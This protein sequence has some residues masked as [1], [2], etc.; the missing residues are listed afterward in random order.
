MSTPLRHNDHNNF[1]HGFYQQRSRDPYHSQWRSL[2]ASFKA[3]NVVA[4]LPNLSEFNNI[5]EVGSGTGELSHYLVEYFS[6]SPIHQ[7][8]VSATALADAA[9]RYP[10]S[11]A[12]TTLLIPGDS[13]PF[14]DN[15]FDLVICS[16]VLEHV[17]DPVFLLR[18]LLRIS[19]LIFIEVP[20]DY[21]CYSI[22]TQEL[23][24][25]GHIHAFSASTIRFYIEQAH[26]VILSSGYSY[27]QS[28][29]PLSLFKALRDV[30]TSRRS[31]KSLLKLARSFVRWIFVSIKLRLR[32][33]LGNPGTEVFYLLCRTS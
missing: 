23:L 30:S 2:S 29:L 28:A 12:S 31:L 22:P 5:L 27:T 20:L 1:Y 15:A 26:P 13:L 9:D 16:H 10:S 8:D 11:V 6:C 33:L 19:T 4:A 3:K 24:E 18:E 17:I 14:R 7:S 32:F 21:R 25:C